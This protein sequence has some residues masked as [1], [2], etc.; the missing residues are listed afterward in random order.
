M[1][2]T[3]V[4]NALFLCFLLISLFAL[5]FGLPGNFL[6]LAATALYGFLTDFQEITGQMLLLLTI[7]TL[8]GEAIEYVLGIAGAKR[9]GSS[10]KGIVFSLIGGFVGALLGAPLLFGLGAVFGALIGAFLG[11]VLVELITLGPAQWRKAVKSGWG[12]FLGRVGGMISKMA[13][14]IGMIVWVA[15]AII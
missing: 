9:F 8:A 13:I 14:G 6:I 11:A 1:I 15:V 7:L 5:F 3:L 10:N 12:N 2:L 4:G